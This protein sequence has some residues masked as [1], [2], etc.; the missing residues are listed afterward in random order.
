MQ[1]IL[2]YSFARVL[3]R[4]IGVV[5][6]VIGIMGLVGTLMW[7]VGGWI[8]DDS[9]SASYLLS[10]GLS[11]GASYLLIAIFGAYLAR[12]GHLLARI[13]TSG[14]HGRCRMCGYDIRSTP[15]PTCPECGAPIVRPD[16][17]VADEPSD[18]PRA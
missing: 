12:D 10:Y 2:E 3:V 7:A 17:P 4:L 1:Q 11:S 15:G 6:C 14:M 16:T 5:L 18:D 9:F 13:V 8:V